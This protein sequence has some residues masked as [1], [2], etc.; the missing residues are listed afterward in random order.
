[1]SDRKPDRMSEDGINRMSE[2][3]RQNITRYDK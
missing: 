3:I 2:G 1:M